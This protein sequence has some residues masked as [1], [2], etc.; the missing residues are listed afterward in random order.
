[1]TSNIDEGNQGLAVESFIDEQYIATDMTLPISAEVSG[2]LVVRVRNGQ[3]FPF[4]KEN[5]R[6][7]YFSA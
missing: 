2:Q 6:G 4:S 5:D 3:G 7:I 1:M